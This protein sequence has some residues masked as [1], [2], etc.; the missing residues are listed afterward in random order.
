MAQATSDI[1]L[2]IREQSLALRELLATIN[3]ATQE[4]ARTGQDAAEQVEQSSSVAIRNA[5]A[6]NELAATAQEI[7]LAVGHLE[8][9]AVTLVHAVDRFK[10]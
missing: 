9:I 7:G 5:S 1:L 3:L 6:S 2:R 4:Q 8:E 10:V